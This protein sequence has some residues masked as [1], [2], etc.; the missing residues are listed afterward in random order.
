M[1]NCRA[2]LI[3]SQKNITKMEMTLGPIRQLW[4]Q[5]VACQISALKF[6][7]IRFQVVSKFKFKSL[8]GSVQI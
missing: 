6:E 2:R 8:F 5:T 4:F 7:I 3:G 1:T